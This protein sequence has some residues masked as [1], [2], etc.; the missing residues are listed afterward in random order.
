MTAVPHIRAGDRVLVVETAAGVPWLLYRPGRVISLAPHA[1]RV[2]ATGDPEDTWT[3]RLDDSW[4]TW[5][6]R[7]IPASGLELTGPDVPP[8]YQRRLAAFLGKELHRMISVRADLAGE[9]LAERT[10]E[11]AGDK[12]FTAERN[13]PTWVKDDPRHRALAEKSTV[14]MLHDALRENGLAA[15]DAVTIGW[16]TTPT[17]DLYG[18]HATCVASTWARPLTAGMGG[19]AVP[20]T[21]KEGPGMADDSTDKVAATV[22]KAVQQLD[23]KAVKDRAK[24]NPPSAT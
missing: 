10:C 20:V 15:Q 18:P 21:T 14:L 13:E 3:V 17:T 16:R 5:E 6:T 24:P 8:P 12:V 23:K 22:G 4:D 11:L 9:Y 2:P 7:P 19:L 1:D